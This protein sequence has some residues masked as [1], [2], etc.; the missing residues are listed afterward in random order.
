[1]RK[2]GGSNV[3]EAF[4]AASL[5]SG[6][7]LVAV[8]PTEEQKWEG[9]AMDADTETGAREAEKMGSPVLPR[10]AEAEEDEKTHVPFRSWCRHRVKGQHRRLKT[11][12]TDPGLHMDNACMADVEDTE[13]LLSILVAKERTTRMLMSTVLQAKCSAEFVAKRTLGFSSRKGLCSCRH[14]GQERQRPSDECCGGAGWQVARSGWRP[15]VQ[16]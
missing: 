6:E 14:G 12:D 4:D 11:D 15:K 7:R 5:N 2:D 8:R 16:R 3:I 10:A 9:E 1:M 13:E